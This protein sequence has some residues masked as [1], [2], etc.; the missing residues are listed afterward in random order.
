MKLVIWFSVFIILFVAMIAGFYFSKDAILKKTA[1]V[2][3]LNYTEYH[4]NASIEDSTYTEKIDSLAFVVEGMLNE[5]T[6]YVSQVKD[7]D[8]KIDRLNFEIEKLTREKS[9]MQKIIANMNETKKNYNKSQEEKKLQD[10]AKMLGSMKGDVLGPI[11]KNLPDRLIQ[12][13]YEK[14]KAKDRAK[15]FKAMPAERA[16]KI[17][18]NL[19]G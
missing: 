10:L 19:A 4:R 18:K 5:M 14:A 1:E 2:P 7:R 11:L 9:E 3:M 16:G 6:R 15:I 17:L 12:I 8:L 13:F